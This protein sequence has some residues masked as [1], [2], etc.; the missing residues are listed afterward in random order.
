MWG[1]YWRGNQVLVQ[2]D[3]MAVVNVIASNTSKDGTIMH[4]LRGLHFVCAHYNINLR[5]SHIQGVKNVSADA[6]SRN[7]LQVFF[8]E[9]PT[10]NR[11]PTRIPERLWEILV[12]T[13]PDWLS[14]HWRQSLASSLETASQRAQR[15]ATQQELPE[16]P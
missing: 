6:I 4:L 9:N 2:C 10:A 3:N 14:E 7:N 15:G 12:T 1:P 16:P 8:K 5:A 11:S 13:Q